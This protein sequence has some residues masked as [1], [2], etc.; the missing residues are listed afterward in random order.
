M[1]LVKCKECGAEISSS[2]K[3]CPKCGKDGVS[4]PVHGAKETLINYLRE[5]KR[6]AHGAQKPR[7]IKRIVEVA[8]T[9]QRSDSLAQAISQRF[10]KDL[11]PGTFDSIK[12]KAGLK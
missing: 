12:K 4:V 5:M 9:A 3:K 7:H 11:N 8:S 10:P 1:A 6:K 2:A